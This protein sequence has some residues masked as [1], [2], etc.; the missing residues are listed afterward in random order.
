MFGPVQFSTKF[1]GTFA[2]S[3]VGSQYFTLTE[4]KPNARNTTPPIAFSCWMS[5]VRVDIL[6]RGSTHT[7]LT[8]FF[9]SNFL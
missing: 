9:G 5:R 8:I 6:A 4:V 7:Q 2:K 1:M 3:T